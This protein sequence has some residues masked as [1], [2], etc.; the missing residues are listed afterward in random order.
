M[1]KAGNDDLEA[2][3]TSFRERYDGPSLSH[4]WR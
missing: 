1:A 2:E 4:T 3:V